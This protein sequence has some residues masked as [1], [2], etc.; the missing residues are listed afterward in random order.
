MASSIPGLGGEWLDT[1][2]VQGYLH[3]RGIKVDGSAMYVHA[4]MPVEF[5]STPPERTEVDGFLSEVGRFHNFED[6]EEFHTRF[7]ALDDHLTSRSPLSPHGRVQGP[8]A[9]ES[10]H[11]SALGN[12]WNSASVNNL[13][14]G[15][16][17]DLMNTTAPH[18]FSIPGTASYDAMQDYMNHTTHTNSMG[19][20]PAPSSHRSSSSTAGSESNTF[21][22]PMGEADSVSSADPD[23]ASSPFEQR[24]HAHN[25]HNPRSV[26]SSYPGKM[27]TAGPTAPASSQAQQTPFT[28]T[29]ATPISPSSNRMPGVGANNTAPS[30]PGERVTVTIDVCK[31]MKILL[32]AS[33]CLGRAPGFRRW[34][35]DAA[36]RASIMTGF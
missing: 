30:S 26:P 18:F 12:M 1:N 32:M 19:P 25:Q 3:E 23:D 11:M 31:L 36:I 4:N 24:F 28:P 33:V 8:P 10:F 2:D 6:V 15:S 17:T 5:L 22:P 35:I 29:S 7:M 27:A 16:L 9:P 21:S 13:E 34:H 14:L 20:A